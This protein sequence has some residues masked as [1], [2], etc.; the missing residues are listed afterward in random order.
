[1][2]ETLTWID[3]GGTSWPLDGSSYYLGIWDSSNARKGGFAPPTSLITQDIPLQPGSSLLYVKTLV[4]PLI[5]ALGIR[6]SSEAIFAQARRNLSQA[7]NPQRGPGTLSMLAADGTH[8]DLTCYMESGFEGDESDQ[9]RGP[10]WCILPAL[11]FKALDPYWYDHSATLLNF[12][13]AGG[14]SFFHTPFI[15]VHLS[16]TGIS[17][18]FTVTNNGSIE[19]WPV[20]TIHG[21]GTNPTLT[22]NTTGDAITL[23]ITLG[24]SDSLVIDTRPGVKTVILNGSTNKYSTLAFDSSLFS[25]A[26][27]VNNIALSM[28][29]TDS[30]SLL[31]L[32]YQQRWDSF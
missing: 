9:Y 14:V 19:C 15:P 16:P 26:T 23:T 27:G 12:S 3:A 8:R 6:A 10:G 7:M 11:T 24:T 2:A 4:R 18:S 30:N 21:A 32:S 22:N 28:T 25:F 29:G 5:L 20:W 13:P 1:M 17:S 31:T